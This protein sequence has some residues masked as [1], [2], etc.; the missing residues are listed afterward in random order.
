MIS[1]TQYKLLHKQAAQALQSNDPNKQ[2]A[3]LIK[4]KS[5]LKNN[6]NDIATTSKML[7]Q[8]LKSEQSSTLAYII[9]VFFVSLPATLFGITAW[10]LI[11]FFFVVVGMVKYDMSFDESVHYMVKFLKAL[12]SRKKLPP[13]Y[14]KFVIV[15]S[16]LEAIGMMKQ[17]VINR[18]FTNRLDS[19]NGR[20]IF[21][22][23]KIC[24][25]VVLALT[26]YY[27]LKA[28]VGDDGKNAQTESVVAKYNEYINTL[29][30]GV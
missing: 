15:F 8:Q 20:R 14:T 3:A 21:I 11:T 1:D 23:L 18:V 17:G 22:V 7:Q 9:R 28:A 10:P 6:K 16:G 29:F 30:E 4:I 5:V 26:L 2:K 19:V 25:M 24:G 27:S 13:E 12:W